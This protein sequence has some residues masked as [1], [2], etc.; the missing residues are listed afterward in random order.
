M[1]VCHGGN[2]GGYTLF[3]K[4]GKLHYVHNYVGAQEFHIE[5]NERV[6]E[7]KVDTPLRI[8]TDRQPRYRQRQGHA[9]SRHSSI[10]MIS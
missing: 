6:P 3:V 5:S 10:S 7:G 4:D 1:I 8:R 2:T 9:G